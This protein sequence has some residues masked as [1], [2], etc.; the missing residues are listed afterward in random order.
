MDAQYFSRNVE[1][2][3]ARHGYNCILNAPVQTKNTKNRIFSSL[4][5][6]P[7]T[8]AAIG[9]QIPGERLG[10]GVNLFSDQQTLPEAYG[11][12]AFCQRLMKHTDYYDQF[13]QNT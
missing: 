7:T 3:Y 2:G 8:L 5:M 6:F 9:C 1:K 12:E 13:F 11:Y 10:L 4:D